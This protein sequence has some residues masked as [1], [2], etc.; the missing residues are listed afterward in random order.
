MVM[1]R[2]V[3]IKGKEYH[4]IT[5]QITAGSVEAPVQIHV[6]TTKL[7]KVE[8]ELIKSHANLL[9]NRPLRLPLPKKS[10]KKP[11]YKFW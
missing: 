9:L 2:T 11:W 1:I 4:V 3:I 5:T 8:K 7:N 10:P 6:D